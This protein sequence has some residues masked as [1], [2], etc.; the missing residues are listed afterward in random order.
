MNSAFEIDSDEALAAIEEFYPAESSDTNQQQQEHRQNGLA[1]H[2][3]SSI[4][5]GLRQS[6]TAVS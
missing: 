5:Q 4:E 1:T 2:E 3:V 6:V